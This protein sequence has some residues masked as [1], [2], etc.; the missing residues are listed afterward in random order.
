MHQEGS[1]IPIQ[2]ASKFKKLFRQLSIDY[3]NYIYQREKEICS[4]GV[5]TD[6][7]ISIFVF[8]Y[9]TEEG[10]EKIISSTLE[11]QKDLTNKNIPIDSDKWWM[12]EWISG[13]TND[14][15]FFQED[16]REQE[17]I[18]IME[19]LHTMTKYS[20]ENPEKFV[21]YKEEI[22][23]LICESLSE[24]KKEGL[25]Y[26][27]SNDFYMLVQ[28]EDNGIYG[29]RHKSLSKILDEQQLKKYIAW[30]RQLKE[31]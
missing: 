10:M 1:F 5:F 17:L 3:I 27:I 7:D 31:V 13:T 25:F 4:F 6:S 19:E 26:N 11:N 15:L 29:T 8:Y 22:F 12:P 20:F 18:K 9:N 24:I 21:Q 2:T 30:D 28:E 16:W 14:E 23:D